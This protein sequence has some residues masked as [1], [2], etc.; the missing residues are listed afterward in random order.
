MEVKSESV[1]K[2]VI[3][4]LK[5]LLFFTVNSFFSAASSLDSTSRVFK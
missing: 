4:L 3:F 1:C 5:L 2:G